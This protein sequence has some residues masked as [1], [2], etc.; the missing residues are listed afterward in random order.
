MF[1]PSCFTE[2]V[3]AVLKDALALLPDRRNPQLDLAVLLFNSRLQHV[4]HPDD[5]RS[6]TATKRA[7]Q[8]DERLCVDDEL[9]GDNADVD[10]WSFLCRRVVL[11]EADRQTTAD[12]TK[13]LVNVVLKSSLKLKKSRQAENAAK[14]KKAAA[15]PSGDNKECARW[16]LSVFY[17]DVWCDG[18]IGF[19]ESHLGASL[20]AV[21]TFGFRHHRCPAA[22]SNWSISLSARRGC[23]PISTDSQRTIYTSEIRS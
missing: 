17:W 13:Q 5:G 20:L 2:R 7:S 10:G 19:H 3:Y 14:K 22:Q 6:G 8:S 21:R 11:D 15:R 9:L 23:P 16:G 12:T 1:I 18:G 4:F